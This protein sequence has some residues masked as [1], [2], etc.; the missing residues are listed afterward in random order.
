MLFVFNFV[1]QSIQGLN[2][3]RS[4]WSRKENVRKRQVNGNLYTRF[5]HFRDR[6]GFY[7][8]L[9]ADGAMTRTKCIRLTDSSSSPSF[10]VP[11]HEDCVSFLYIQM[12]TA[13][14]HLKKNAAHNEI[15]NKWSLA[16]A[17][18]RLP[19]PLS[20][21]FYGPCVIVGVKSI[22]HTHTRAYANLSCGSFCWPI[23]YPA[24]FFSFFEFL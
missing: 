1:L 19:L 3:E 21:F 22:T 12:I 4:R 14:L 8:A 15:T 20:F 11:C 7:Y 9:R 2:P 16:T 13:R 24:I 23:Y 5:K 17:I 6:L 10:S 18:I